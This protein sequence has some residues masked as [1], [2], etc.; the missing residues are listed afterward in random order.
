MHF[1]KKTQAICLPENSTEIDPINKYGIFKKRGPKGEGEA[2]FVDNN[3]CDSWSGLNL[4][5][6]SKVCVQLKNQQQRIFPIDSG[7]PLISDIDRFREYFDV[8][9]I[10]SDLNEDNGVNPGVFAYVQYPDNF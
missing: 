4:T 3:K 2:I 1:N 9:G 7:A 10:L 8:K 6:C 5:C